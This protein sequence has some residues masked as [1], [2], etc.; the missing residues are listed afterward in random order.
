MAFSV[1]SIFFIALIISFVA[2]LPFNPINL[3]MIDTTLQN[4]LRAGCWFAAAA[5][6]VELGQSLIA[7]YGGSW[8]A[9]VIQK[10]VWMKIASCLMFITIGILFLLKKDKSHL[11]AKTQ[12]EKNFFLRGLLISLLSPQTIAFWVITLAFL[13]SANIPNVSAQSHIAH[14]ASFAIGASFG[15]LGALMLFGVWSER[16]IRHS[17][18]LRSRINRVMGF[19]LIGLGVCQGVLAFI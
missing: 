15:K 19:I 1:L 14:I 16:I 11:T 3:I 2:S 12:M 5:A 7:V 4:S 6:M 9:Q 8:V 17:Q 18:T 10:S 13:Q